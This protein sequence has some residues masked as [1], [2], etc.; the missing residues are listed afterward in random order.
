MINEP[1][2]FVTNDAG[3]AIGLQK[4]LPNYHIVCL[5]DSP[6]VN[7][8]IKGGVSIFCLEKELNKKNIFNRNSGVLLDHPLVQSFI[9]EKSKGKIPNIL[10]FKPQRKIEEIAKK[11]NFKLIGNSVEL[12]RIFEDKISFYEL[13]IKNGIPV[14][15]GEICDLNLI[16]YDYL[17]EKYRD[18][19]VVQSGHGWAG[20]STY[21]IKNK[22]EF[23]ILKGELGSRKVK[24][25]A[26]IE[27]DT[28]LNNS[29]ILNGKVITGSYA[30]QI[31]SNNKLTNYWGGTGGR[32][33]FGKNTDN[34]KQNKIVKLTQKVS[35]IMMDKGYLGF[36][37]L[38]F[39]YDRKNGEIYMTENNARLTASVSFFTQLEMKNNISPLLLGHIM[40]FLN[41]G[42]LFS[43]QTGPQSI[44][45]G[46]ITIKNTHGSTVEI[47]Q[48]LETGIYDT[49]LNLLKNGYEIENDSDNGNLWITAAGS[50]RKVNPEIEIA[51]INT[52][53]LVCDEKGNLTEEYLQIVDKIYA[54]VK[55]KKV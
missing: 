47:T 4:L 46:E 53:G 40:A 12:N 32:Q 50:G 28:Y 41:R 51:R 1:I 52:A 26:Y 29:I 33:W 44:Q 34:E 19:F 45:G 55:F 49:N 2:F 3:R 17:N 35:E 15:P 10:F 38:D 7:Y 36:F 39:L 37:G 25:T 18:G 48:T 20:N 14:P 43:S 9:E 54:T 42:E 8:L 24:I 13:C 11:N 6:L 21:F 22:T 31:K 23:L 16:E 27:G 30:V 5:D